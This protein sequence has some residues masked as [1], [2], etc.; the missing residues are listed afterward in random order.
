[1]LSVASL[2]RFFNSENKRIKCVSSI[3]RK[4]TVKTQQSPVIL[5]LNDYHE[6]CIVLKKLRFQ[7]VSC[8]HEKNS[9]F[10]NFPGL[11]ERFRKKA[12]LSWRIQW[13]GR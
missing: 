1:M 12:P 8:P 10:S 2:S 4:R 7:N 13:C 6:V 11:E 3:L 9:A 5:D